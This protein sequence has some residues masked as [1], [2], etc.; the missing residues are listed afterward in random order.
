AFK[1]IGVIHVGFSDFHTGPLTLGGTIT[2][3]DFDQTS[4]LPNTVGASFDVAQDTTKVHVAAMGTL[5]QVNHVTML[6]LQADFGLSFE[7][8]PDG[9][10]S[11]DVQGLKATAHVGIGV[12]SSFHVVSDATFFTPEQVTI[13]S[14][15]VRFGS[16]D[17]PLLLMTSTDAVA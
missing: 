14:V 7:T 8:D 12:D 6:D 4:G 11:L 15:S 10:A 1:D 3:G 2:L 16:K 17:K 5:T 9:E 13:D